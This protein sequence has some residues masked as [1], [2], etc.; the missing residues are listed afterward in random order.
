MIV[1]VIKIDN[2][3]WEIHKEKKELRILRIEEDLLDKIYMNVPCLIADTKNTFI[4]TLIFDKTEDDGIIETTG[5][6]LLDTKSYYTM[7]ETFNDKKIAFYVRKPDIIKLF[8]EFAFNKIIPLDIIL[9]R[10]ALKYKAE[11]IGIIGKRYLAYSKKVH[12]EDI[13]SFF[14]IEGEEHSNSLFFDPIGTINIFLETIEHSKMLHVKKAIFTDEQIAEEELMEKNIV[15]VSFEE[16]NKIIN[17]ERTFVIYDKYSNNY[18][19]KIYR[20]LLIGLSVG[21]FVL[22][23]YLFYKYVEIKTKN[24]Y[25]ESVYNNLKKKLNEITNTEKKYKID[26][27]Y[28][29]YNPFNF[30]G[31]YSTVEKLSKEK[32]VI[33]YSY[34]RFY[35]AK[36]PILKIKVI[37]EGIDN[38]LAFQKKYGKYI[39]KYRVIPKN[40]QIE[41]TLIMNKYKKYRRIR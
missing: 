20:K 23:P 17:G 29:I 2:F 4:K 36:K 39:Q 30:D 9:F 40:K 38:F 15:Q 26:Y 1:G 12:L 18:Q 22:S 11:I 41:V 8:K 13:S 21:M 35:Y 32:G 25:Y 24:T 28:K 5:A 33:S 7:I 10:M 19:S 6:A 37:I 16:F 31:F 27:L 34:N 3:F 14:N